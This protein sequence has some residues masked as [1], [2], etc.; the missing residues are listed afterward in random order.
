MEKARQKL[1]SAMKNGQ[2]LTLDLGHVTAAHANLKTKVG[3][4]EDDDDGVD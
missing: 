3:A 2:L 1:V 4:A